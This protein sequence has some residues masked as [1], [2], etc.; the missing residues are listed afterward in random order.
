MCVVEPL[1]PNRHRTHPEPALPPAADATGPATIRPPAFR[2]R[3]DGV[4]K[5]VWTLT[6]YRHGTT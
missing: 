5:V 2:V 3:C 1:D 6:A 4:R